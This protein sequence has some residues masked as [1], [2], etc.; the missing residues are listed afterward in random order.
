MDATIT[1]PV[2]PLILAV[3]I[4]VG[5]FAISHQDDE[6]GPWAWPITATI[7]SLV[8]YFFVCGIGVV[9]GV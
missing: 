8:A 7:I 5:I 2:V 9:F 1:L 4:F 6:K 3:T